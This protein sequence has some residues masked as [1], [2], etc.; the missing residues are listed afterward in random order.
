MKQPEKTGSSQRFLSY[1]P[2]SGLIGVCSV[3]GDG[4]SWLWARVRIALQ[5]YS[6]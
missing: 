2:P 4:S 6:C 5:G 1:V 3:T